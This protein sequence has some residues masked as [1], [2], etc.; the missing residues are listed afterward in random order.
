MIN[1]WM[2]QFMGLNH[3]YDFDH[4]AIPV[5]VLRKGENVVSF[6]SVTKH[7]GA[8]ILWPGPALLVRYDNNMSH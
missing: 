4:I 1:G 5:Q 3:N 6:Y 2:H 7:H 8:E